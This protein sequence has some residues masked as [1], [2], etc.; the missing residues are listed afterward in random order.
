MSH[1]DLKVWASH[2]YRM[3]LVW[4]PESPQNFAVSLNNV[5]GENVS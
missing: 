3:S 4:G 1:T 2:S 5:F